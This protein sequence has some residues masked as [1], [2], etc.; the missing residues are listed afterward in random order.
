MVPA[1]TTDISKST[2]PS[3]PVPNLI[4]PF[5]ALPIMGVA[6]WLVWAAYTTTEIPEAM[7]SAAEA[8]EVAVPAAEPSEVAGVH[9]YELFVCPDEV[10][11][12]VSESPIIPV[13]ALETNHEHSA[14]PVAI[15]KTVSEF[16]PYPIMARKA[17]CEHYDC[18]DE[19]KGDAHE[20]TVCPASRTDLGSSEHPASTLGVLINLFMFCVSVSPRPQSLPWLSNRFCSAVV[21]FCLALV[22][23]CSVGSDLVVLCSTM[24]SCT[25]YSAMAPCPVDSAM[26]PNSTIPQSASV[27]W[28][29]SSNDLRSVITP[30]R[31]SSTVQQSAIALWFRSF[32]VPLSTTRTWPSVPPPVPHPL[33]L[34]PGLMSVLL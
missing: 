8:P 9:F 22:V 32:T 24:A 6:L 29:R 12:P 4:T 23:F 16:P 21:V 18:P 1:C 5:A 20:L 17:P 26:D 27:P 7:A 3:R 14:L 34:P 11:E 30:W 13:S 19:A 28:P 2:L 15:T 10:M 25:A 33:H 31:R